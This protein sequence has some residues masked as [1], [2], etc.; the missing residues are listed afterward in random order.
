MERK[1]LPNDLSLDDLIQAA[2]N[3]AGEAIDD[4]DVLPSDVD[5]FLSHYRLADGKYRT[6]SRALYGVYK[7][8]SKRPCNLNQFTRH[9]TLYIPKDARYY[10]INKQPSELIADL[11]SIIRKKK[12]PLTRK[13][14]YWQ[15]FRA[16]LN[17][18]GIE[19]GSEWI[20][21]YVVFHFYS[22]WIYHSKKKQLSAVSLYSFLRVVFETRDTKEGLMIKIKHKFEPT[23]VRNIQEAWK[24]KQ[25]GPK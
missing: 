4:V 9:L 21:A 18:Y 24:R 3:E 16:F 12:P 22:K 20:E 13:K 25:K 19:S 8:W 14:A 6:T 17:A 15:H 23:S 1:R 10:Y 2:I 5:A 11:A 7:T